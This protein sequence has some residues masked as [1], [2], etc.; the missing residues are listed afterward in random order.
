[1]EN[2]KKNYPEF[3]SWITTEKDGVRLA[4]HRNWFIKNNIA[5]YCLPIQTK[6]T[7]KNKEDFAKT[8]TGFLDYFY[9]DDVTEFDPAT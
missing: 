6:L 7:G 4:L 9:K 8:I 5:L 1:M 2:I 3:T